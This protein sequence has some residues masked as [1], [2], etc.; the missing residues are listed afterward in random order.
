MRYLVVSDSH[1]DREILV[2]LLKHYSD[3]VDLLLH[4]GDSEL[5]AN[6]ELF[7]S[8]AVVTGNCDYDPAFA[9]KKVIKSG[10]DKIL[11]AHGHL[12]GVGINL[13]KIA[14]LAENVD[15]NLVFFGHTHQLGTEFVNNRLYLNPGSISFPRGAYQYVGGTY[16]IV[17]TT[18]KVI[19]VQ[20]YTRDMKEVPKLH[21]QFKRND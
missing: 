8:Y 21:V 14:S 6:D 16:C 17:E 4:C 9:E 19:D 5:P 2:K 7:K 3:K 12:L 18:T 10:E 13:Q 1:G 20:Y 11:L 15:A